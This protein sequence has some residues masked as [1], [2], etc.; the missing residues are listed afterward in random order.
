MVRSRVDGLGRVD[1]RAAVAVLAAAVEVGSVSRVR[2]AWM[3]DG[4]SQIL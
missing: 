4:D 1:P 2:P 3:P